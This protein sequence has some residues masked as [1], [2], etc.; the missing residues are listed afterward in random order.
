MSTQ[1]LTC[2]LEPATLL[3]PAGRLELTG[4]LLAQ[5]FTLEILHLMLSLSSDT[6]MQLLL[7]Q[8]KSRAGAF[9]SQQQR[10]GLFIKEY[11]QWLQSSMSDSCQQQVC[12]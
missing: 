7:V 4:D 12:A 3:T 1:R 6:T 9:V 11:D 5:P 10:E 2:Y 8:V